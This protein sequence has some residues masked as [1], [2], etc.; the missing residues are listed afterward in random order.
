MPAAHLLSTYPTYQ[1][2]ILAPTLPVLLTSLPPKPSIPEDTRSDKQKERDATE[3]D[4]TPEEKL[5]LDADRDLRTVFV[6]QLSVKASED[7]VF[8][9]MSQ[10]GKVNGN[11]VAFPG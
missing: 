11:H 7:D 2:S 9:L 10:A 3:A 5:A 6:Y 4:L 1:S 8:N